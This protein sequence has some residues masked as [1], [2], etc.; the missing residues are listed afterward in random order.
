MDQKSIYVHVQARRLHGLRIRGVPGTEIGDR[1]SD[2]RQ[3]LDE[4]VL[5]ARV[6]FMAAFRQPNSGLRINGTGFFKAPRATNLAAVSRGKRL[7]KRSGEFTAKNSG[8]FGSAYH[9]STSDKKG[10]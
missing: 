5:H 1:A 3:E 9:A 8:V 4:R 2:R 10:K 7:L 6:D